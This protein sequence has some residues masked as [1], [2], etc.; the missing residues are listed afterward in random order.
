MICADVKEVQGYC[1]ICDRPIYI[2]DWRGVVPQGMVCEHCVDNYD[3]F[4]EE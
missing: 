4:E 1:V 2:D 3:D